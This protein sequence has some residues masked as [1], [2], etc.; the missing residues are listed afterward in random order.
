MYVLN[1]YSPM[2][3]DQLRHGRKQATIR[4]GDKSHKYKKGHVVLVTIGP[5]N[6][7]RERIFQAVVD[8]VVVKKVYDL[9]PREIEMDNP[10]FRLLEDEIRFLQQIYNRDISTEDL[11]TVVRFSEII[12]RPAGIVEGFGGPGQMN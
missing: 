3:A 12:D 2:F 9:T 5:E 6:S 10:E 1:F 11:V 8:S 7:P 4:L